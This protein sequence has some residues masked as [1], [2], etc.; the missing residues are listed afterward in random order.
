MM[1]A[2]AYTNANTVIWEVSLLKYFCGTGQPRKLN[3]QN[4]YLSTTN[5]LYVQF[6]W[7]V[8]TIKNIFVQKFYKQA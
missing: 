5:I 1:C 7:V 8:L 3:T 4:I 6:L 2:Y